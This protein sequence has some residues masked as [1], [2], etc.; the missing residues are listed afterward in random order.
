MGTVGVLEVVEVI[1]A[2]EEDED[3][4]EDHAP[5]FAELLDDTTA[6]GTVG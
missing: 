3:E 2:E 1:M 4:E 5:Q 6:A